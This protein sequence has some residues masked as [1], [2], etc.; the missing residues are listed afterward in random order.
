MDKVFGEESGS[1]LAHSRDR[2]LVVSGEAFMGHVRKT[3][4]VVKGNKSIYV[5]GVIGF[6]K[7]GFGYVDAVEIVH[8]RRF[9]VGDCASHAGNAGTPLWQRSDISRICFQIKGAAGF[10][11]VSSDSHRLVNQVKNHV[12]LNRSVLLIGQEE[13]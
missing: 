6:A 11:D 5:T 10:Q 9:S 2:I 12:L 13:K 1:N 3:V 4:F 7:F 8:S